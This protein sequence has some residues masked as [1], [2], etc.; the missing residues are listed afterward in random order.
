MYPKGL[1]SPI[2]KRAS[3]IPHFLM[4]TDKITASALT[5]IPSSR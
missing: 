2:G 1:Y 4:V 3:L 5:L